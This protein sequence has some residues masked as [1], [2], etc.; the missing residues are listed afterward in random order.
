M[1]KEFACNGT[2]VSSVDSDDEDSPAPAAQG[3]TAQDFGKILQLQ[4]DQRVKV[5]DFLVGSGLV[6]TKEAKDTI[7]MSVYNCLL[8]LLE[9]NS[10]VVTVIKL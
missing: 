4:G 1:K 5:K 6:S 9:L 10:V 7:V 8:T 3:K 2:V